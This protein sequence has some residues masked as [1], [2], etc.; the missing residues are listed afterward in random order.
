MPETRSLQE[1]MTSV[2]TTEEMSSHPLTLSTAIGSRFLQGR[3]NNQASLGTPQMS[4]GGPCKRR[5][6][7][8]LATAVSQHAARGFKC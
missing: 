7:I 4:Q 6:V 5:H 1:R 3:E 8:K 2:G